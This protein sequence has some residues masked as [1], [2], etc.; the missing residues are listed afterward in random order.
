MYIVAA[1]CVEHALPVVFGTS[2]SLDLQPERPGVECRVVRGP[3]S[4]AP[5]GEAQAARDGAEGISLSCARIHGVVGFKS[6]FSSRRHLF[7]G[8]SQRGTLWLRVGSRPNRRR[9]LGALRFV[10]KA[11]AYRRSPAHPTQLLL[12]R[13]VVIGRFGQQSSKL[14]RMRRSRCKLVLQVLLLVGAAWT[15]TSASRLL[16]GPMCGAK[17]VSAHQP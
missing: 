9:R 17:C 14:A 4:E 6:E 2:G 16:R 12:Q 8:T 11:S 5:P 1:H 3:R 10:E 15:S 13:I 7:A